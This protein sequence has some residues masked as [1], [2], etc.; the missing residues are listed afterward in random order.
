MLGGVLPPGSI[1]RWTRSRLGLAP[2]EL[3]AGGRYVLQ[4]QWDWYP[5]SAPST[6]AASGVPRSVRLHSRRGRPRS[7]VDEDVAWSCRPG[8]SP[9]SAPT[10]PSCS[11]ATAGLYPVEVRAVRGVTTVRPGVG[12]PRRPAAGRAAARALDGP[13]NRRGRCGCPGWTRPWPP[14]RARPQRDRRPVCGCRRA[15]P[16]LG[17]HGGRRR[18]TRSAAGLWVGEDERPG[19]AEL[20]DQARRP[21]AGAT[22][23]A[24]AWGWLP[25]SCA[26]PWWSAAGAS[27]GSCS[28]SRQLTAD[29]PPD[30]SLGWSSRWS[31]GRRL[32]R[33]AGRGHGGRDRRPVAAVRRPARVRA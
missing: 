15:G 33:R 1:D 29:A 26:W 21:D 18:R 19:D 11:S 4:R 25:P 17:P 22:A 20:L 8:W 14:A 6:A 23:S 9:T 30:P 16:L 27:R 13:V 28:A 10:R 2:I 12:R 7:R 5:A 31:S 32:A 24:P 3:P